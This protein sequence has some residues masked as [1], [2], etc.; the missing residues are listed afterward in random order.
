MPNDFTRTMASAAPLS[1]DEQRQM[2]QA[3]HSPMPGQHREFIQQILQRIAEERIDPLKPDTL[4]NAEIY[5]SL[6]QE[7]KAKVD[8]ALLNIA[9]QLQHIIEFY[10]SKHTPDESIEL[11]TMIE[12][13]WE[14]KQ[15]IEE[16]VDVFVF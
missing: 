13:L 2:T 1:E 4:L 6:S 14:M 9:T 16:H 11:E 5:G 12:H 8:G 15:R 7:W 3:S 10:K